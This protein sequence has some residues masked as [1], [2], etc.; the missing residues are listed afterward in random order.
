[1]F[2]NS[3]PSMSHSELHQCAQYARVRMARHGAEWIFMMPLYVLGHF[4]G[5]QWVEQHLYGEG[6]LKPPSKYVDRQ[7]QQQVGLAGYHLAEA[8]FNL[9]EVEGFRGVHSRLLAGE[10]EPCVGEL[11]AAGFL[12][13]RREKVRFV[14]PQGARGYD[15]DLVL[16]RVDTD[17]CCE[18]KVKLEAETLTEK[19]TFNVLEAV[20]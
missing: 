4:F 20:S 3:N 15:Y 14:T 9:Q 19:G 7:K 8:L 17:I 10:L 11:D 16:A 13:R 18:V 1:M 5:H 12:K 6:F 2:P